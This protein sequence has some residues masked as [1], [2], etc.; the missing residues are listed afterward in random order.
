MAPKRT[1]IV[2]PGRAEA[3]D[4]AQLFDRC[5][6]GQGM[7]GAD[8]VAEDLRLPVANLD[9]EPDDSCAVWRI[10]HEQWRALHIETCTAHID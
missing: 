1:S 7:I 2:K 9:S 8:G 10:L 4:G 3:G 5:S 6:S